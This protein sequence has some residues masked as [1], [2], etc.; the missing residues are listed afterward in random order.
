MLTGQVVARD[1]M[2][3]A[4]R[5]DGKV[6]ERL[7]G[8]GDKVTPG[9]IVA[10]LDSQNELNSLRSAEADIASAQAALTQAEKVEARQR[11]LLGRG[12]TTRAIFD[13]TL[14]QLQTAQAQLESAQARLRIAQDRVNYTE[15]KTEVTGTVTAKGAE[16]GEI[17]RAGQMIVRIAREDFKDAVFDLPAQA[18]VML[19][20]QRV[21]RDS[22]VQ[23]ALL[24]N[25]KIRTTGRVREVS[26]Q[27][28]PLTR[29]YSIRM[30]LNDPP[31][32][33]LLGAAV[34]GSISVDSAPV[35]T[36]P[37]SALVEA[38]GRPSVWVVDPV[39]S[40]VS[41]RS[42]QLVRYNEN[43][44]VIA[45]GL[46]DGEVVVTAGVNILHPGQKVTLLSG[47]S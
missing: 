2:N 19:V 37:T 34:A 45:A 47:S 44:L 27:P 38:D 29:S 23:V 8:V 26:P 33:M 24:S 18:M 17:V 15:L 28:D 43:A 42:I 10:R 30:A 4:F 36:L 13:Q 25:P 14:Q 5:I 31:Q 46:Q 32:E 22:I 9:A 35:M 7:V 21:A 20:G 6:I 40:T 12:I 11:D 1:E 41:L 39:S 16:A 3:L